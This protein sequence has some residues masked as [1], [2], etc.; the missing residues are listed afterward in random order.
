[1]SASYFT[2]DYSNLILIFAGFFSVLISA[3]LIS[4]TLYNRIIRQ[5]SGLSIRLE[6][7][8][9]NLLRLGEEKKQLENDRQVLLA[10]QQ[11]S[12]KT[13]ATLQAELTATRTLME[14]RKIILEKSRAEMKKDFQLLSMQV[15][16]QQGQ[17]LANQHADSLFS[18]LAPVK[19]QLLTFK[20]RVEEVYDKNSRDHAA[21]CREIELLR[22]LNKQI[23]DEARNLARA[24]QGENKLQGQW[25]EMVLDKLLESSGLRKGHEFETQIAL[26]DEKGQL[27]RPDVLIRLPGGRDVV[28]DAK[29]SLT[30]WTR[31]A[32]EEE[33]KRQQEQLQLHLQSLHAHIR[34]LAAK[35]YHRLPAITSLD[36]VILFIPTEPAFQAALL[37]EPDL[38]DKAMR[39]KVILAS[40][41]TLLA[42]LRTI[43]NLWRLDEQGKNSLAIAKQAGNLYDKFVGFI[44]A[45]EEVGSRLEQSHQSWHTARNRLLAGKGNLISRVNNLK[46]LG[47]QPQREF[48]DTIKK[49][50]QPSQSPQTK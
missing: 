3:L 38:P 35:A 1:M 4:F 29:V 31:A 43:H 49:D 18:I 8:N 9:R 39:K 13:T 48:P 45:F 5:K 19:E 15:M 30:A 37:H 28:I 50:H 23:S 25:G 7:A 26:R 47:I 2:I 40:P 6:Q 20:G 11:Q 42:I 17:Q 36:F 10:R 34:G 21:L 44:E 33:P 14:E 16:E 12:I 27:F 24:L 22:N 46:K 41:S 32:G